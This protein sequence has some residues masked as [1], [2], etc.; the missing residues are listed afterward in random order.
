MRRLILLLVL[1]PFIIANAQQ[2]RPFTATDLWN[3]TRVSAPALSPDGSTI[4][5][6]ASKTDIKTGKTNGDIY[7][8]PAKGGEARQFTTG[9]T[10]E[11]SPAWSPDGTMLAFTARRDDNEKTQIYIISLEGGEARQITDV[12]MGASSPKWF[13]DGKRIAFTTQ[14]LFKYG[15]NFDSLKAE[16][17]RRKDSKV[18][19]K[20]S[21]D[22]L[23]RYWDHY[24]TDEYIDHIFAADIETKKV[25][26]LTPKMDRYFD[27][28]GGVD[29]DIAPDGKHLLAM[30]LTNGKPYD[31]LYSDIYEIPTDGSGTM[32]NLTASNPSDDMS[33]RYTPDG[34]SM[35]YGKLLKL[36]ANGERVRLMRYN[37]QTGDE[38]ELCRDFDRSPGGWVM[39]REGKTV[40]FTAEDRAKVSIFSAPISGGAVSE[41]YR[42]GANT[43][44]D[45]HDGMAYFLHQSLTEPTA[46]YRIRTNGSDFTQLTH[47]NDALLSDIKMGTVEDVTFKGARGDDVQMYIIYPPDFDPSKKWPL[48]VLIHGG[49]VGTF[50]DDFHPRWNAQLFAAPGYVCITPNFHGS[51]SFGEEFAESIN[52]AHGDMPFTDIMAA[53]DYMVKKPFIDSTRMAAGGGSYG[54]YLTG[55]IGGQTD[56][57]KC[58]VHHAGVYNLMA[59]FGSDVTQNRDLSYGGTPWENP[60]RVQRWSPAH[61]AK[62]YV[63]PT[64]VVHGELDYRVP[65]NQG[66]ELYGMLKAKGVPARIIIYPD[67]NHWVLGAN[68]SIHWYQEYLDWLKR[69]V[70]VGGK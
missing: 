23:F 6:V 13:P 58:L 29:F 59:Q 5:V 40:Y 35:L 50:G 22:R 21:E 67:E 17:K 32:R 37:I 18:S 54:G 49:P 65:Y 4:A 2:K 9:K 53:T 10:T 34:K 60:E 26:D 48:S 8:V 30:G 3:L 70:D 57:F 19:A 24:L 44:L 41:I 68:N 11:G 25:T 47:F 33:P 39:D 63:T 36:K 45:V 7:L 51:S 43:A 15:D 52:G 31:A 27:Y 61:H 64:L 38:I 28:S 1:V 56:R 46:L 16:I 62:N 55:W 14:I 20:I 66:L 42:G 12:P 69:W